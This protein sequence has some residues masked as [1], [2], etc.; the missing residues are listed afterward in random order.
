[1]EGGRRTYGSPDE[2]FYKN[3]KTKTKVEALRQ[4]QLELI[5]GKVNRE[6]LAQR[7][8]GGVGKLWQTAAAQPQSQNSISVSQPYFWAIYSCRGWK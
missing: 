7:G 2:Q 5:R 3:L 6:L 8:V 4:S 1:M